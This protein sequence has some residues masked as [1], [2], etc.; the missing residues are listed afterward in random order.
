MM[1]PIVVGLAFVASLAGFCALA[2][3]R[4]LAAD[5]SDVAAPQAAQACLEAEVNPVT[6]HALCVSPARGPGGGAA[7]RSR[8][9]LRAGAARGS[10]LDLQAKV[11][12]FLARLLAG[13][14][15]AQARA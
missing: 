1:T 8:A 15:K 5:A 4:A 13:A 7:C 3:E 10:A 2:G 14:L 6:G 12:I 9:A 11:Q